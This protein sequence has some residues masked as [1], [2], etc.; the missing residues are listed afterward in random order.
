M[1]YDIRINQ[2]GTPIILGGDF[3]PVEFA[4]YVSQKIYKALMNMDPKTVSGIQIHKQEEL[5]EAISEYL[6]EYFY[7]DLDIDSEGITI[8]VEINPGMEKIKMS[9]SYSGSSPAGIPVEFTSSLSYSVSSGAILSVD[10]EPSWLAIPEY[11]TQ[12]EVLYPITVTSPT[13]DIELPMEPYP[14]ELSTSAPTLE[15]EAT[16][17]VYLLTEDQ[18]STIDTLTDDTFSISLRSTRS[19]Y[20]LS[21][22]LSSYVRRSHIIDSYEVTYS[23]SNPDY[24]IITEYGEPVIVVTPGTTGTISGTA[25]L[26]QAVQVTSKFL[27]KQKIV[28][29]PLFPLR[30]RRGKY[31]AVFPKSVQIGNYYIK[32]TA[33]SELSEV[34]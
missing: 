20:Q 14:N 3:Y 5:E 10:Y 18:I 29:A 6:A 11:A 32:Y 13:T 30:R 7:S 25:K 27:E 26:R 31:F 12:V 24:T 1:N 19:K 8:T 33:L 22:Y 15:S 16:L 2:D 28:V 9:L 17:P 21:S 4:E 23:D 34:E